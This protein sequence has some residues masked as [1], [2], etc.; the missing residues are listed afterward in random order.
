M[1]F[2]PHSNP[3]K[4]L[5][6]TEDQQAAAIDESPTPPSVRVSERNDGNANALSIAQ[7]A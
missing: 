6:N 1:F 4:S 2:F 5:N 3:R 7:L